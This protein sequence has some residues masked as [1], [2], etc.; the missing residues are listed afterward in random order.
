MATAALPTFSTTGQIIVILSS[1]AKN[2]RRCCGN[3]ADKRSKQSALDEQV[4]DETAFEGII[5]SSS[6]L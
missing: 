6:S 3:R 1:N 4:K 5:G 2:S